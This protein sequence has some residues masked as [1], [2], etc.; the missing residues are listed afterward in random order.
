[1]NCNVVFILFSTLLYSPIFCE[2]YYE[3][4]GISRDATSKEI[5]KAFKK[6]ALRLH[7]DKNK[8]DPKAHDTFT[9]INKAYEVLKDDELRKKYD[10]YGE[11]GLKDNHFSNQYQSWNYFN[12]EFGLYDE[13]PEIITLSYSDFQMSVEGSEDIWFINYYS[14]FCS[15]CHD[16]AP[17]WRE[18]ARD[19]EGV[20]RFGAVNCQED[21]GLCQR[22][23]IRSYPSLV[24]YP[25]QHLYHGS[26]TTSALVK[27]IL[28]EID[29]KVHDLNQGL[30]I[31]SSTPNLPSLR[32]DF[33]H[34][35]SSTELPWLIEFCDPHADCLNPESRIKL[36][37]VLDNLVH[38]G[39]FDCS[40]NERICHD[41]DHVGEIVYFKAGEIKSGKGAVIHSLDTKEIIDNVLKLTSG[42]EDVDTTKFKKTLARLANGDEKGWLL[43]FEKGVLDNLEVKKLPA[44]LT[45]IRIG[46]VDC[47][48][49]S[50]ICNEYHVRK[51]PVAALF[52]K[53]GFEWHYGRFTAHDIALFAKE[54]VSSNV[55]ALGPEDF[56]SSVI[57]PSRPFFVDF[58]AP[59]CPPCMRLLPEYRKAARS[60]VGKPVGFGTVDCT[61]HSQLC[62][63]YNIRSYP[64]TIL[65]NNSQPHQ[66]IGHH[67]AL[68]IIEFVENTLKPSVV[69]LSP[70]TFES[71]VH[72]KKIGETWLVDFYA[73]WCG[74]CQ[75]LLPDWNKLA[76][77]MEGETFLGS[78]D[79]VA[80]RNLCANQG[81]RSYPT[82]RLY[83]HTSRGG[84]DFVVHQGWRDVDS[85]HMWAYNYLP[86]IVSEVN[87]KNFF[88]D[89]LASE[90]AWVVDFYAPWCGPCMRFAPKYEQL[91]K[92]LKGKV[93]AAKVNCEQDYGLC[94]EANIHS[95][96]T[97]R[98]YLGSTRQGMTQSIN[99]DLQ[100]N[101]QV[102]EELYNTIINAV[103]EDK[104][105][106][107]DSGERAGVRDN[108]DRG[109]GDDRDGTGG[110]RDGTG[111]EQG[112]GGREEDFLH[113]E[114]EF[115]H[116]DEELFGFEPDPRTPVHDEF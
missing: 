11:E 74:P 54:S 72:N 55:H 108:I 10:L 4:F 92:M 47:K 23:G 49:S 7:P 30:K 109:T 15:H 25:T 5:R 34:E 36:S 114:E 93:R 112:H 103:K 8:D 80:H 33:D 52:K 110:D 44:V 90:D 37:A 106:S 91:A 17:T 16:L 6:L 2:D 107:L 22:Q 59:W 32:D 105:E 19:L 39:V 76:K 73:P 35:T 71:L 24:L 68:D 31:P 53:A 83:S 46:Y 14:P 65:Y 20:V 58:F 64:T 43:L 111:D 63:Q 95:Y 87:S 79:C 18:V 70:E 26:R 51:Y 115:I 13:D 89:V 97:V 56:P 38:I 42:P 104:G 9:R 101:S 41:L 29:A 116:H 60:F 100:L 78:V 48:K 12:E 45:D 94:S 81:I 3:L 57:S 62:H 99:G 102:P 21:W 50:E 28:D 77:R 86:S 67:N 96:P 61:V 75:E 1:M 66:F 113:E 27:F 85:L 88:T 69:Q 82:I 84:W 40:K 98:L